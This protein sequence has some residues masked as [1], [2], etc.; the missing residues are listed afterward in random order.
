[1]SPSYR[2]LHV[3]DSPDDAELVAFAL[4]G[5]LFKAHLTRVDTE[6]EFIAQLD[7]ATPD[8]VLCD[9]DLPRFSAGRALQIL[10]ER[11][12]EVPFILISHHIGE[13]AAVVAMQQGASGYLRKSDLSRLPKAIDAAL[14]RSRAAG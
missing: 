4:R 2:I 6:P 3:E 8:V 1:M 5:A 11:S 9:Y 14:D 7:E 10:H 13:N 12:L